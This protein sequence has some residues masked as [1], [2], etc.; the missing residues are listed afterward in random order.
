MAKARPKSIHSRAARR[1][2]SPSLDLDKSL[3]S[4]PRAE[5]TVIPRESILNDRVNTGVSKKQKNKPLTR[6]QRLR[7]QKGMER[8]EVVFDQM[9]K[10]VAKSVSRAKTVKSRRADWEALNRNTAGSM[11][12]ALQEDE[13]EDDNTMADNSAAPKVKKSGSKP[14]KVAQNPVPQEHA[15]IDIDDD[16]T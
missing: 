12:Q 5:D 15:D 9:E 3:T 14:A 7:Q 2:A 13:D 16:I 11:F 4:L 1:A 10:K 8:A 6:A